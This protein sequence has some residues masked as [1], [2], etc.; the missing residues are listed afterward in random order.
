VSQNFISSQALGDLDEI[1][2]YFATRSVE[3]G[4][5]FAIEFKKKCQ[6]LTQ[7]PNLGRSYATIKPNLRGIP[8]MG[9]IIFY[10]LVEGGVEIV[11]VVSAYRDLESVFLD[12]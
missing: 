9:Y 6:Y 7:F 12:E 8:L 11:R 3:A 10:Q 2:D 5:N 1:F 4:E